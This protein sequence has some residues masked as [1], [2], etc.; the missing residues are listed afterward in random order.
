MK[1]VEVSVRQPIT[2]AVGVILILLMGYVAFQRIPVRMTPEVTSVV[3]AVTTT[4]ENAS[5]EEIE[6]DVIEQQEKRLGNLPGIVSMS[7]MA[8]AGM[9]QIRLELRTGSDIRAALALVDQ[10][11]GEV[12]M[13]PEGVNQPTIVD[14]DPESVDYI[15]WIG[16][17]CTDPEFDP[18]TMYDFLER[19]IK[20][21]FDR[22]PGISEVGVRGA[23]EREVQIRV[24]PMRLAERRIP[25]SELVDALRASNDDFSGGQV[26][27]GKQDIRV[28]AMGR[29]SEVDAVKGLV[30]RRQEDGPVYL[31]EVADVFESYKE[32]TAFV[33][34]RGHRMPFLNFQLETGGNLLD[35]MA[36]IKAEVARLNAPGGLFEQE[37]RRLGIDGTFE[38]VQTFDATTYVT[39]ALALV[40][41]NV[42]IGGALATLTLLLF[43]RSLRTIGII[44]MAIPISVIGSLIILSAL[45]RTFNIVSLAGIA[46]ATGMVVDNA[47]VVLE[48]IFRHLEMG[49]PVRRASLDGA[50]EVSS[51]VLASTLTT[52]IVFLPILLIEQAAGQLF[53]DI[54]I[55]IMAAVACSFVVAM[56]LIPSAATRLLRF[57][58]SP[59][60][61]PDAA[62]SGA[63]RF[64]AGARRALLAIADLPGH[65]SA[66]VGFL[67]G[68]W[69][70][71]IAV[72]AVF[73][74]GTAWGIQALIPPLDYLPT[75]N[76][77]IVFGV[78]IPPPGYNLDKLGVLANRIEERVR[79]YW[80]AGGERFA[81]ETVLRGDRPLPEDSRY[82]LPA[83][84]F[85]PEGLVAP[86]LHHYFLVSF[87]G[88]LFHGAISAEEERAPDVM[89]L[90]AHAGAAE[91]APDVLSFAFQ[92][93]LFRSGGTSG[94]A[95][96]VDLAGDDIDALTRSAAALFFALMGEF[97]PRST[98]PEPSNF[99]LPTTELQVLPNDERLREVGM[100]RRD[101]GLAVQASG[102]GIRLPRQFK[103]DGELKDLRVVTMA[104]QA[105]APVYAM[106]REPLATPAGYVVDLESLATFERVP[107]PERIKRVNRQRAITLQFTPP[108]GTPLGAAIEALEAKAKELRDAGGIDPSVEISMSG[109][110]G[111]LAEIKRALVGDG[112]FMGTIT[113][114]LVLAVLVV[115]LLMAVLFQSWVHPLVIIVSVPLATLGGF[116]G[117]AVVHEWSLDD[118]Y[119]PIQN[120]D[121]LTI[122]GFVIL[123]GIVVNN[124]ILIVYQ[125]LNFLE[126]GARDSREAVMESVRSR[127]RPILMSMATSVGGMLPLVLV[128]GSGSE[129]YRGLG[130][131][132]V[133]GLAVSTV[134]TLLLVPVLFDIVMRLRD[135]LR[136]GG[137][138]GGDGQGALV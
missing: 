19:R 71:R 119:M 24:D 107:M 130:A 30:I 44:A 26:P 41:G 115:Y 17:S 57:K 120:L 53:K 104:S 95:I 118:P 58:K 90:M 108:A 14:V 101:L 25:Y 137:E 60:K 35:V 27:S 21:R 97:G 76:R 10:K 128:P 31:G 135:A 77:N 83:S 92:P 127:V 47:I 88:R 42:L 6:S 7:S 132:V 70:R 80:E 78:L 69:I 3:I 138:S 98:Q 112:T 122:L 5:P 81:I 22:I 117:L 116:A 63:A 136:P 16:F 102:D 38:L 61:G 12:P 34:T 20:P 134:F 50:I 125:A 28:R 79:P 103:V 36:E 48:N 106:G 66:F 23:Q 52:L 86:P 49:K 113:S 85:T 33:R 133:G 18:T 9:G 67:S 74:A 131:V 46:F 45:G 1:I 15:A 82:P 68:G 93:P 111:Q 43:L 109:S 2:V 37:A 65:V 13:Y 114:S 54:A 4:W 124:A 39:D 73:A 110:A 59:G 105:D 87:D 55:A 8:S 100:T 84:P 62:A 126:A 32:P 89:G 96:K 91:V 121:V 64:L 29:F 75:G 56:T 123:A 94:S 72:V 11:L 129:L 51:A 40:R 99:L